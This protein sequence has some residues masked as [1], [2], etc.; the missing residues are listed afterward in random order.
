MKLIIIL[1]LVLG[2]NCYQD[3]TCV[4]HSNLCENDN[5]RYYYICSSGEDS[6]F[7]VDGK[8]YDTP[9]YMTV[10]ECEHVYYNSMR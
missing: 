10:A 4:K 7:E 2:L 9:M 5:E 3:G 8:V 6:W 1:L